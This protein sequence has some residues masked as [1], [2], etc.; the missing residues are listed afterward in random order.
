MANISVNKA[1]EGFAVV[2]FYATAAIFF[3]VFSLLLHGTGN[4]ILGHYFQPKVLAIVH[5]L[6]LGWGTMI[7]LGAAYQLIPV[8]F[9]N[10]LYSS[11]LAFVSY[12][13]LTIGTVLLIY[14]FWNFRT[15]SL[16]VLAGGLIT[17]CSYLYFFLLWMT[18][19]DSERSFELNLFFMLSAFWFCFTT[20]V[21]LILA[22][23]LGFPFLEKSHLEILKLHAHAGIAGWF[24][25]LVLGAAAKMLPMFLLGKSSKTK[26]LY[27]S[28]ILINLGLT[29]F[30]ADGYRNGISSTTLWFGGLIFLGFLCWLIYMYDCFK[31]RARKKIDIPMR[32]AFI[33]ILCL[34]VAFLQVPILVQTTSGKWVTLY[35]VWIFLGWIT[36]IILG[37]TFK[38]LPFIIWNLRYKDMNG[39]H[40]V[41][42]P[43]DLYNQKLLKIQFYLFLSCLLW[44]SGCIV[45][46]FRK[47][48]AIG[49]YLWIL[50]SVSYLL[51]VLKVLLHKRKV[52]YAN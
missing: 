24:L 33:S 22:I 40:K 43:K 48:L 7:I 19:K 8:I 50:L 11:S 4:Q 17:L 37:M 44:T 34:G 27:V 10:K 47:G 38:T 2:P 51:N 21:G 36:S 6:A 45:F 41:P 25:Q 29:M 15:G 32:H 18:I 52:D 35:A 30:L 23:N 42:M 1:P 20:T 26:L 12:V 39:A 46:G 13:L 16:M 9:E 31:S 28:V 14:C 49:S 5:T 3:L